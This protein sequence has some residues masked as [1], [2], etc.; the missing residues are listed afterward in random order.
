[1]SGPAEAGGKPLWGGERL[2]TG[3]GP[4]F[5][6]SLSSATHS[7]PLGPQVPRWPMETRPPAVVAVV[8]GMNVHAG[9]CWVPG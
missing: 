4:A 8:L 6:A 3:S 9:V 2:Q 5:Q 1:M 7:L